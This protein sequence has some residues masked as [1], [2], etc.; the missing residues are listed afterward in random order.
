LSSYG[1]LSVQEIFDGRIQASPLHGVV[2][3]IFVVMADNRAQQVSRI[4]RLVIPRRTVAVC[5]RFYSERKYNSKNHDFLCQ[6]ILDTTPLAEKSHG[7]ML[8]WDWWIITRLFGF[9][10]CDTLLGLK[11]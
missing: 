5:K 10:L 4:D 3:S 11:G 2:A 6:L 8:P 1:H 7:L 9:A